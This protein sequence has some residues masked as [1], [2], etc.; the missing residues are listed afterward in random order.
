MAVGC[1]S[2]GEHGSRL[3]VGWPRGWT[4]TSLTE[5][6]MQEN[7]PLC[8]MGALQ[9]DHEGWW[10]ALVTLSKTGWF[11]ARPRKVFDKKT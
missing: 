1:G 4:V 11:T 10:T 2:E 9:P 6:E 8:N 5:Q 7:E 3:L